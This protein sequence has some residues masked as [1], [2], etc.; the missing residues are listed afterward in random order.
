MQFLFATHKKNPRKCVIV[1]FDRRDICRTWPSDLFPPFSII[2]DRKSKVGVFSGIAHREGMGG[3]GNVRGFRKVQ[4]VKEC[5]QEILE[6][7]GR[8]S[9][10]KTNEL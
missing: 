5:L 1:F 7:F 6:L 9:L 4:S 8:M 2:F 3:C 10:N